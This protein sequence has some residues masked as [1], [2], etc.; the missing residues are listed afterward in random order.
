MFGFVSSIKQK[1]LFV[2]CSFLSRIT[3]AVG[4]ACLQTA[5]ITILCVLYPD[6]V[7]L[8]FGIVELAAVVGTMLGP[9]LCGVLYGIGGFKFPLILIGVFVWIMLLAVVLILPRNKI[10]ETYQE[11]NTG[12]VMQIVKIPGVAIAGICIATAGILYLI[13]DSTIAVQ[14]DHVTNAQ[15]GG[16]FLFNAG[17]Y[18][19]SAPIC[20]I[21]VEHK[22]LGEY[23]TIIGHCL[24][25][26]AFSSMGP[27]PFFQPFF[28]ATPKSIAISS[29]LLGI[30]STAIII[31]TIGM[32]H[33][34]AMDSGVDKDLPLSSI[35]SG[36]YASALNIG[37]VIG[38]TFGG[39]LL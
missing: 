21:I 15:I 27:V 16:F 28:D 8:T 38:P 22:M 29:C 26:T 19:V 20:G 9:F 32:M 17:F 23:V 37:F 1:W 33:L 7:S 6:H 10:R 2:L 13:F 36:L 5:I 39:L 12:S 24:A 14:L 30:S 4:A 35:S 11:K 3:A 25:I 34:Y 18:T 31:P